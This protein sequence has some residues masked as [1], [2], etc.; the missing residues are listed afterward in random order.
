ML[1]GISLFI[2][3]HSIFHDIMDLKYFG[4]YSMANRPR[5]QQQAQLIADIAD[6]TGFTICET[7]K[8]LDAY[9]TITK[10]GFMEGKKVPLPG[11]MGYIYA[12]ITRSEPQTLR[13]SLSES[14]FIIKP[15]LRAVTFFS[16]PWK[17]WINKDPRA[18]LLIE[19]LIREKQ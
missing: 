1:R 17:N 3:Y 5:A 7:R 18:P 19:K 9:D 15:R 14:D 8:F 13:T 16:K 11:A 6:L 10:K 12:S 2:G 4:G